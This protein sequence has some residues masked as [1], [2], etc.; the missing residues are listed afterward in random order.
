MQPTNV[1]PDIAATMTNEP[2]MK[3]FVAM[4]YYDFATPYE[5]ALYTFEHLGI[6]PS[7]QRNITYRYY[8]VGH[9]IYLNPQSLAHY[10]RD[11][12]AWYSAP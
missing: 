1:A 2:S 11:L 7:L 8:R 5:A 4:G 9:M 10:Q 6:P 3:V 12:D